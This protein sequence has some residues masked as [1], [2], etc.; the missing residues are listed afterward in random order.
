MTSAVEQPRTA[1]LATVPVWD[2][3]TNERER[4]NAR[5]R[6]VASRGVLYA[7]ATFFALFAALPFA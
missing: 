1:P 6:K 4:R 3:A 7:T 5:V 2:A